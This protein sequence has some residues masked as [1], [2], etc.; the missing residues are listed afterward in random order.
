MNSTEFAYWLQGFLELREDDKPL[1]SKQVQII[2]DHLALVFD[3][4]T[5]DR[6]VEPTKPEEE[7]DV[8]PSV[9]INPFD[10]SDVFCE[11][12]T[13]APPIQP[14]Q[15]PN[16]TDIEEIVKKIQERQRTKSPDTRTYCS[17]KTG[18]EY[19]A[20]CPS[21]SSGRGGRSMC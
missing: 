5:P 10:R 21:F 12:V 3:K 4:V 6:K 2:K 7:P 14:T 19:W 15:V 11:S 8:W 17:P 9:E 13:V 16:K 20:G 18:V 1:T